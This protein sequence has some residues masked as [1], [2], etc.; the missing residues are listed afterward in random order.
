MSAT[1][2]T[3][4]GVFG[5]SPIVLSLLCA[6]Y[7][8]TYVDR[9]NIAT[10]AT[11]IKAEFGLSNTELGLALG[12]F[13]Y[14]YALFQIIGGFIGDKFGPR[15]TLVAC[16]FVWAAS[17]A[18]TG[19]VGGFVSPLLV[20]VLLGLGEGATFPTATRALSHWFTTENRGFAQGITPLFPHAVNALTP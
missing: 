14:A 11:A 13:G 15:R 19:F 1:K 7:F 5:P 10:A 6:M 12:I 4:R 20:R 17:T 2:K 3:A 18:M 16:G 8:I 9:V